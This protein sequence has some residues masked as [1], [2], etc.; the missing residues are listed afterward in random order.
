MITGSIHTYNFI[1]LAVLQ[2]VTCSF[3]SFSLLVCLSGL[4][5][6]GDAE[7][8]TYM[9][10]ISFTDFR[11]R[12]KSRFLGSCPSIDLATI[13][14]ER[15]KVGHMY[16]DAEMLSLSSGQNSWDSSGEI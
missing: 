7:R 16:R 10:E 5:K 9:K 13:R 14:L 2:V 11:I 3:V 8:I 6:F 15:E 12:G 4:L 1:T